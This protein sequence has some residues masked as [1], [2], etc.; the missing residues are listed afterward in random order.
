LGVRQCH[1]E[2][3]TVQIAENLDLIVEEK[4]HFEVS[5]SQEAG[6]VDLF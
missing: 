3:S 6:E 2:Q 4:K 1:L 5:T